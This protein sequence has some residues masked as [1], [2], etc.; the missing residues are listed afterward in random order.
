MEKEKRK[1]NVILTGL[2]KIKETNQVNVE[3][4]ILDC[5]KDKLKPETELMN[6]EKLDENK[7]DS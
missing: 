6:M 4:K 2:I 7:H 5:I 3:P 1:D